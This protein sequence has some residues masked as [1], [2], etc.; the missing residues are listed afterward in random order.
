MCGEI[1][2]HLK[3]VF[4]DLLQ[5]MS[6]SDN[7]EL[8]DKV[9]ELQK[10]EKELHQQEKQLRIAR[11]EVEDQLK[12]AKMTSGYSDRKRDLD[13]EIVRL[14]R[15]LDQFEEQ[16]VG[17]RLQRRRARQNKERKRRMEAEIRER[18]RIEEKEGERVRKEIIKEREK[19]RR[20]K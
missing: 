11:K 5:D 6:A 19:F 1:V 13:A 14:K 3:L 2:V 9:K 4:L 15:R 20:Y 18:V 8:D 10:R 12:R 16:A 17:R 7:N